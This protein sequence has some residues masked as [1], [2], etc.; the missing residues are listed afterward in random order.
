V[1]EEEES[2][3]GDDSNR[4]EEPMTLGADFAANPTKVP[5]QTLSKKCTGGAANGQPKG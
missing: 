3:G 4:L 5:A 2:D 1:E